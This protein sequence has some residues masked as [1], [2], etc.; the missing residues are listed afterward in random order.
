VKQ[1]AAV[2]AILAA[3]AIS[4]GVVLPTLRNHSGHQYSAADVR[5]ALD[6]AGFRRV[7]VQPLGGPDGCG[8]I[9]ICPDGVDPGAA[10]ASVTSSSPNGSGA[11]AFVLVM[12]NSD[13]AAATASNMRRAPDRG[14]TVILAHGNLVAEA[15]DRT[16][17]ALSA[18]MSCLDGC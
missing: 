13:A 3:A 15:P 8:A 9:G 4:V 6:R 2:A 11:G 7:T 10:T 18:F 14:S 5:L 17:E 1:A 16:R 12:P